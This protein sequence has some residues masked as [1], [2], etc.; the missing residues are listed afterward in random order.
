MALIAIMLGAISLAAIAQPANEEGARQT[1]CQIVDA[2]YAFES[3]AGYFA[4]DFADLA[5]YLPNFSTNQHGYVFT[6]GGTY[7][8]FKVYAN[9]EDADLSG[10]RHFYADALGQ[11]RAAV[12]RSAD[13]TDAIVWEGC[14]PAT[15]ATPAAQARDAVCAI[16]RAM[17]LFR[18]RNYYYATTLQQLTD[19][20]PYYLADVDQ[21]PDYIFD[22]S[23]TGSFYTLTATADPLLPDSVNYFA[24]Y[25]GR[26]THAVGAAANADSAPVLEVCSET[27]HLFGRQTQVIADNED[28]T[29]AHLCEVVAAEYAYYADTGCF[30]SAFDD[31]T[32]AGPPYLTPADWANPKDGYSFVLGGS[33][34]FFTVNGNAVEYNIHG[35]KG[36]Y[37]D[38]TGIVRSEVW[39][40]ATPESP[41]DPAQCTSG[42]VL[43]DFEARA[44]E[45]VCAVVAAER[46]YFQAFGTY[47]T[48]FDELTESDPPFL[49][50]DWKNPIFAYNFHL[51]G[52][53]ADFNVHTH[54]VEFN[55]RLQTAYF[56]DSTGVLRARIG[57]PVTAN[58][59]PVTQ[60]CPAHPP[61]LN[62][63]WSVILENQARARLRLCD[64]LVAQEAYRAEQ[65]AYA[66]E[67]DTLLN[68][69]PPYLAP[70]PYAGDCPAYLY[71]MTSDSANTFAVQAL[72]DRLGITANTG[73]YL[74][75][76]GIL[77]GV[78]GADAG[79]DSPE[80][81]VCG[82]E[83]EGEADTPQHSADRN[84]DGV[85][86]LQELLR[87]IQLFNSPQYHCALATEDGYAPDAGP[88]ACV[89]HS[90]DYLP[91][92]WRINLSE[93]LRL[94][95]FYT[96]GGIS[97][98]TGPHSEDGFCPNS[99]G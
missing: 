81:G 12:D 42:L 38:A 65:G 49:A 1:I 45:H 54:P 16:I 72:P 28:A 83:G 47:T 17:E 31:L 98:C 35:I 14:L 77:R 56:A 70:D 23:S 24:D 71:T 13:H 44:R 27:P 97:A 84:E 67:L 3:A 53:V 99:P 63:L 88:Q 75:Q 9:P 48:D 59:P 39:A 82:A 61:M 2:Q 76:T 55:E 80:I 5:A 89:P 92:D 85:I 15:H 78:P 33:A 29:R 58:D 40:D 73:Y 6:L 21:F 94:V 66:A 69:E 22:L 91:Q 20:Y 36:F 51:G 90:S 74:D 93:L 50:G 25:A 41:I 96:I 11:I 68:A 95:Q 30:T 37:V 52:T 8:L 60:A 62:R 7:G 26:F 18:H 79:P 43:D 64:I 34:D 86:A 46:L 10:I 32:N 19:G 4:R 57:E 87:V